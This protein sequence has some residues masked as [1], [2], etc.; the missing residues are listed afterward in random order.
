M[1]RSKQRRA[2]NLTI[3][4]SLFDSCDR[5]HS[6][7]NSID[8]NSNLTAGSLQISRGD[9][10]RGK[11]KQHVAHCW[12]LNMCFCEWSLVESDLSVFWF[13]HAVTC[14]YHQSVSVVQ[15]SCLSGPDVSLQRH[16]SVPDP[17]ML[18]HVSH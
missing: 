13:R 1:R 6:P 2:F 16:R 8:K 17:Q 10:W 4:S 11:M 15:T 3:S 7:P 9:C 18:V 14:Y 12:W 5:S